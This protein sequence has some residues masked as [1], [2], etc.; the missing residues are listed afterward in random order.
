MLLN[1]HVMFG[2][3]EKLHVPPVLFVNNVFLKYYT[4]ENTTPSLI[5]FIV[6]AL[7][8]PTVSIYGKQTL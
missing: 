4:R 7:G 1:T 5:I 2:F 3:D 8:M 6:F